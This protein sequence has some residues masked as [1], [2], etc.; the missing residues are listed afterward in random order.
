[1]PLSHRLL[2]APILLV[3]IY[4]GSAAETRADPIT[5]ING[6]PGVTLTYQAA[7]FPGT[8]RR[9]PSRWSGTT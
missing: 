2:C 9:P 3:V 5:L 4:L 7:N 6:G 8:T 1:M